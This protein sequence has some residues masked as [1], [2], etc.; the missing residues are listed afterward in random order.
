MYVIIQ[1]VVSS[2]LNYKIATGVASLVLSPVQL[3][4]TAVWKQ[5]RENEAELITTVQFTQGSLGDVCCQ[6]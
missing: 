1:D 3:L 6:W 4:V 2:L 5:G